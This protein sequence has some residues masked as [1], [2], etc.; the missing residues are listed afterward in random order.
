M[1]LSLVFTEVR[2]V[3]CTSFKGYTKLAITFLLSQRQLKT[4]ISFKVGFLTD[5]LCTAV[6]LSTTG[7]KE[8]WRRGQKHSVCLQE[9]LLFI[10]LYN[11]STM[12][13]KSQ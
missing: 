4:R 10:I 2:S 5:K 11:H 7:L 3:L 13:A 6:A 9:T 1:I 12:L 8:N